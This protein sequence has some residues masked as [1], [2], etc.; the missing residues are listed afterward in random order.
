MKPNH[1]PRLCLFCCATTTY[2]TSQRALHTN[3]EILICWQSPSSQTLNGERSYFAAAVTAATVADAAGA[4][5]AVVFVL[6]AV[7][8]VVVEVVDPAT[9][10]GALAA[11]AA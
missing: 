5:A 2:P 3:R 7:V 8:A 4:G 10:A 11:A 6:V 1:V 9:E